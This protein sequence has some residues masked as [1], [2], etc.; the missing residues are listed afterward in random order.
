M[1]RVRRW[2]TTRSTPLLVV[3]AL[4]LSSL[5]VP[6]LAGASTIAQTKAEIARLSATLSKEEQVSETTANEY[7]AAKVNLANINNDIVNLD[8]KEVR[9]ERN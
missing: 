2:G 5:L 9:D 8:A 1:I 6:S 4:A 7:D 3:A